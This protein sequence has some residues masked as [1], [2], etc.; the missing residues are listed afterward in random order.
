MMSYFPKNLIF[1][2]RFVDDTF[3]RR[4]K[5]A[6]DLL[7]ENLNSY[8]TKINLTIERKPLKFLDTKIIYEDTIQTAVHRKSTK[9]P[10]PWL[11]CVPKR[12]KRNAIN[13]DLHRAYRISSDFDKEIKCI[14]RKFTDAGYPVRFIM[15]VIN[16]FNKKISNKDDDYI[17]PP[18]FFDIPKQ[19]LLI[20]LPYCP[21]NELVAKSFLKRLSNFADNKYD[22]I[23]IWKTRKMRS[24]FP[25]KDR[26][27]HRSC[28]IY[29]GVCSCGSSY[30]GET[31]RNTLT[32]WNEHDTPNGNTVPSKHL[33]ANEH[34]WFTWS[35]LSTA[36]S[37]LFKR[38]ILEAFYISIHK[39]DINEQ[40]K[41]QKLHLFVGGVT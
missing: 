25:L 2:K 24:L 11:S 16:D 37:N 38:K 13:G 9:F 22:F 3:N 15:S 27:M 17:I 39:P 26:N 5:D 20:E 19:K 14:K 41:S 21:Q 31:K 10:I 6:P 7:F 18:D 35:I 32:R 8:H 1:Y 29:K 33:V 4:K 40:M 36:P 28:V 23:I 12:Y 30:V 34:H